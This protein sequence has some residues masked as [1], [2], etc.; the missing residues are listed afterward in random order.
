[1]VFHVAPYRCDQLGDEPWLVSVQNT[2]LDEKQNS[3]FLFVYLIIFSYRTSAV[4][5]RSAS[6][7]VK[8]IHQMLILVLLV[9]DKCWDGNWSVWAEHSRAA[10][11]FLPL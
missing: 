4:L 1:M 3:F 10:A 8:T 6:P 11:D 5:L 2:R 9:S 7:P